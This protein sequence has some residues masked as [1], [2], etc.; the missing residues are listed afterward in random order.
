MSLLAPRAV[1]SEA[2]AGSGERYA[3][4]MDQPDSPSGL[5][6]LSLRSASPAIGELNRRSMMATWKCQI[7]TR[8]QFQ[9]LLK[10]TPELIFIWG[11]L[12]G[13]AGLQSLPT[14]MDECSEIHVANVREKWSAVVERRS[15]NRFALFA[16]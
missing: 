7:R 10:R 15:R 3:Y 13:R 2:T 8:K 14:V 1:T 12:H 4:G 9:S 11:A 6:V 16:A 5:V